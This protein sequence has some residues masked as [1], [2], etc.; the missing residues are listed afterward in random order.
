M[1]DD[2]LSI[3]ANR[4]SKRE[5]Q[6][7]ASSSG[8][9]LNQTQNLRSRRFI[10]DELEEDELIREN[11]Q[12][13]QNLM[14]SQSRNRLLEDELRQSRNQ[15][16]EDEE[17]LQPPQFSLP[18]RRFGSPLRSQNLPSR[19]FGSPLRS[20]N[21]PSR[22]IGSPLRSQNLPSRR[23]GNPLRSQNLSSRRVSNQLQNDINFENDLMQQ[24]Q[25]LSNRLRNNKML[26]N[27]LSQQLQRDFE[28]PSRSLRNRQILQDEILE[29]ELEQED[30]L[31]SRQLRKNS[32][33]EDEL[34]QE[35]R[36]LSRQLRRN[37]ILEDELE[38][39]EEILQ[40]F[41]EEELDERLIEE[42]QKMKKSIKKSD[43]ILKNVIQKT[44]VIGTCGIKTCQKNNL[45]TLKFRLP[46]NV[47]VSHQ[48]D[49]TKPLSTIYN[50]L[51][52]DI[53]NEKVILIL[54]GAK[55]INCEHHIP[56]DQ[57]GIENFMTITVAKI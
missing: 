45:W 23:F 49:K 33:L 14:A 35:D 13:T 22:R 28:L 54:P 24:D 8:S 16:I 4:L 57:T 7:I 31:L 10:E 2:E 15:L 52:Q 53:K 43:A 55:V 51:Q 3:P 30:R 38:Q 29:D 21:L 36:L 44:P 1:Y 47:I 50:Q 48:F 37:S 9:L 17:L 26:Q 12:L 19:R 25:M 6:S 18:S 34:E 39:E 40:D 56:I 46:G 27:K 41:I 32:I 11:E 5:N 42:A 20:Q